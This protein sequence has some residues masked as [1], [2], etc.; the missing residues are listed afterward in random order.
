MTG[1]GQFGWKNQQSS[2]VERE[3]MDAASKARER[4]EF[5]QREDCFKAARGFFWWQREKEIG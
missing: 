5:F 3:S 1:G 2:L 4:D